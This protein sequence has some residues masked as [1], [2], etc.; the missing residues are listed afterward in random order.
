MIVSGSIHIDAPVEQ[1]FRLVTN[2]AARARLNPAVIPIAVEIEGDGPLRPGAVCHFRL[3]AGQRIVDYRARITEF[4]ANQ[5]VV[6]VSDTAVPIEVVLE[7][8]PEDRGTRFTHSERFEPTEA[9][10]MEAAPPDATQRFTAW[11]DGFMPFLDLD[12]A[13][14][15]HAQREALLRKKLEGNLD[16]WLVAIHQHLE[17]ARS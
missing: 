8:K 4:E 16:S 12:A 11:L 14:H 10:L 17:R 9:M 1:V 6:S 7:T 3:Q 2:F 13:K 15:L 5:R